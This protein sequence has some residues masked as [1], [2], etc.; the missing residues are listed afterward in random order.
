MM[1]K[2][3][4]YGEL[5]SMKNSK[6]LVP[7]GGRLIPIKSA[8]A[9]AYEKSALYQIPAEAK[10]MLEGELAIHCKCY[11]ASERP[12]LDPELL[13]DILQA[14]F[15]KSGIRTICLRKGVY[16]NDRQ[17][18]DKHCTHHIDKLNPRVEVTIKAREQEQLFT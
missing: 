11:Y 17:L 6:Q 12:D 2:F 14:K 1:I 13:Y 5:P 3:T 15:E 9:L 8:K 4:I 18:R 7:R 10:Q 16:H